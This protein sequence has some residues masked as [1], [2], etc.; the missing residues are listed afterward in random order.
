MELK[1]VFIIVQDRELTDRILNICFRVHTALGPGLL[2]SVY[3]ECVCDLLSEEGLY[4]ERQKQIPII[5]E[6]RQI[7]SSLKL[8]IIVENKVV[9]ELKSVKEIN[10]LFFAQLNTYLKLS[11]IEIG[12][13][14]NF[15]VTS[16]KDGIH[17]RVL[18][19]KG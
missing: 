4:F 3:E 7:S 11:N 10:N 5:F 9:L 8:D 15:N 6:G 16:L 12:L 13:L 18:N 1:G 2:E 14:I 17:R 19:Y